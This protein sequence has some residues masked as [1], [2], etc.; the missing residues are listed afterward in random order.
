MWWSRR[1]LLGLGPVFVV[2]AAGVSLSGCGFQPMYGRR[3]GGRTVA[4]LASIAVD[5]AAD[6]LTQILRND[7][8]DRLTPRGAP[9]KPAYRLHLEVTRST[10]ALAIQPDATITRYNLRIDVLFRLSD[11]ATGEVIHRGRT[12]AVGSYNAVRSDFATLS[13]EL[14][15]ARRAA[16]NASAEVHTLLGVFFDRLHAP[17]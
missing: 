2:L 7:L 4:A 14:D 16:R 15:S 1:R 11:T 17:A 8:I 5:P 10:T 12:R 9:A 13:A 3:G 6:R